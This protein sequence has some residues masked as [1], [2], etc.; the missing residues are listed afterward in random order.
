MYVYSC[1]PGV[2]L[3][4]T[5][6]SINFY[7]IEY[8]HRMYIRSSLRQILIS[9][10][11]GLPLIS[12]TVSSFWNCHFLC[13]SHANTTFYGS[14]ITYPFPPSEIQILFLVGEFSDFLSF[15]SFKDLYSPHLS[16]SLLLIS[17]SSEL[18]RSSLCRCTFFPYWHPYGILERLKC[19]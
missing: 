14:Y 3:I 13:I 2:T 8:D 17:S 4:S 15:F 16:S 9:F 5:Y 12:M 19:T 7:N 11:I 10:K 18:V 6:N 1:I